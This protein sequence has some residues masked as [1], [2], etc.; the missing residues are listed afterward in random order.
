M[1]TNTTCD[2]YRFGAAPPAAPSVAAVKIFLEPNFE[3][4]HEVGIGAGAGIT[5]AFRWTH[6]ALCPLGTDIRDGYVTGTPNAESAAANWDSV[7]VPDKNGT[8]FVVIFAE[9]I[10]Y[11][12]GNDFKKV[13]LQR[14][15]PPW[16]TGNL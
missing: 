15:T 9:R 3:P 8:P 12:T 1:Q 11:G 7:Y 4:S 16:P 14:G 6:V 10:G 13:Y 2:V 5:T